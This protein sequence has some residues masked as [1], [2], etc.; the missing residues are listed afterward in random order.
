MAVRHI[1]QC[2]FALK[3]AVF[4]DVT[5]CG[6]CENRRFGGPYRLRHESDKIGELGTLTVTSS[7]RASVASYC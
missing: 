2:Q 3:N 4:W 1:V 6:S 5:L 7:Q